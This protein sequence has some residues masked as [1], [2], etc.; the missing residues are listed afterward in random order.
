ME[1]PVPLNVYLLGI[2]PTI[3]AS[4]LLTLWQCLPFAPGYKHLKDL[5]QQGQEVA[6]LLAPCIAV[7]RRVS[8][9]VSPSLSWP[10]CM[11][12]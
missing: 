4:L 9:F 7:G 3:N 6:A 12:T 5:R 2:G 10:C 1:S 11:Q 8:I